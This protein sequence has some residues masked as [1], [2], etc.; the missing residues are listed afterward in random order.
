[1][2]NEISNI[3]LKELAILEK[4]DKLSF[5]VCVKN[6]LDDL[7]KIL[8]FYN[9]NGNFIMLEYSH[10][11]VNQKL[12]TICKKYLRDN[13]YHPTFKIFSKTANNQQNSEGDLLHIHLNDLIKTEK[14]TIRTTNICIENS[15]TDIK[16]IIQYFEKNGNFLKLRRCGTKSNKE[17]LKLCDKYA[18][19]NIKDKTKEKNQYDESLGYAANYSISQLS[20]IE[21][22]TLRTQNVCKNNKLDDLSIIIDYYEKYHSFLKLRNCGHKSNDE[23]I[24][25]AN[26]YKYS[27]FSKDILKYNQNFIG[28][29]ILQKIDELSTKQKAVVN[30]LIESKI[31][32]LSKRSI[33]ALTILLN[34]SFTAG[35]IIPIILSADNYDIK[36]IKNIGEGSEQEISNF[37]DE[38]KELIELVSLFGDNVIIK[39]YYNSYLIK[40]YNVSH[41]VINKISENYDFSLGYPIFKTIN[42]FIKSNYLLDQKEKTVFFGLLNFFYGSTP[43]LIKDFKSNMKL[44]RER[45]RQV[46]NKTLKRLPNI[47]YKLFNLELNYENLNTYQISPKD[48]F[49]NLSDEDVLKI[50]ANEDV[51][52]NSQFIVYIFSILLADTHD[53]VGD[54]ENVFINKSNNNIHKWNNLYLIR[55][56]LTWIFD[57]EKFIIDVHNRVSSR[58]DEDFKFHFQSYLLNFQKEDCISNL[59]EITAICE[60]LIYSEFEIT[61]DFDENIIFKRNTLKQVYEYAY[62]ALEKLGEPSKV[63]QI[64]KKVIEL[65]PHYKTDE[66]S[67]RASM[68]RKT[69]FVT[70]G[71]TSVYGL[72]VWEEEK[73]IRG[74][75]IRDIAEEFLL[76]ES[77]PQHLDEITDYI[78]RYRATNAKNIY[79]N[80]KMEENN[81]FVFYTGLIIGLKNKNYNKTNLIKTENVKVERKTWDCRYKELKTFVQSNNRL[82]CSSGNGL[83]QQLYRFMHVQINK[84]E[85]NKLEQSKYL[86]IKEL[87]NNYNYK[88]RKRNPKMNEAFFDELEMFIFVNR[89]IPSVTHESEKKLYHFLFRQKKQFRIGNL[90]GEQLNKY[91]KIMNLLNSIR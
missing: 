5:L 80:L 20:I 57:F 68:Q 67:I 81:R 9:K 58:I 39:E 63:E 24:K 60:T 17:L 86:K 48:E 75:T 52:F 53:L 25:L 66:E 35:T 85:K 59:E 90:K 41:D 14:L 15:L 83:E 55:K 51:N 12:L 31:N 70:F 22:L 72:K 10:S 87:A 44:T 16:T 13:F 28:N 3:E 49:I 43:P 42:H 65:Y 89:R 11:R 6:G 82:P 50:N 8:D 62:E 21:N 36:N 77:E 46:R 34:N 84:G 45:F 40:T 74:G 30:N 61:L 47:I 2:E 76:K 78:N 19:N 73:D 4:L 79:S 54:E 18:I 27:Q 26:K 88:K 37:F 71:R 32:H 91:L 69:G 38:V 64:C 7:F 56:D 33:N 29:P 23:L 1:M